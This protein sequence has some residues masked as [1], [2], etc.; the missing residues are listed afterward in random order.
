MDNEWFLFEKAIASYMKSLSKSAIVTHN[1]RDQ[2]EQTGASRQR[3]VI[4]VDTICQIIPVKVLISCKKY[5]RKLTEMDIDHFYG[6]LLNS[7]ANKGVLY[8]YAGFNTLAVSKA[9]KL[10]ISCFT[11]IDENRKNSPV[12]ID[13]DKFYVCY[14][15]FYIRLVEK[16]DIN[17]KYKQWRDIFYEKMENESNFTF[18]DSICK[19]I[20]KHQGEISR[21]LENKTFPKAWKESCE[22]YDDNDTETKL[23]IIF[24]EFWLVFHYVGEAKFLSGVFSFTENYLLGSFKLSAKNIHKINP[25]PDWEPIVEIPMNDK[26]NEVLTIF[27]PDIRSEIMKYIGDYPIE[28]NRGI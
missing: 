1:V 12:K 4:I 27:F 25:G 3:D 15:H 19:T 2:D 7:N 23:S 16:N 6:E 13:F 11:L 10:K 24:G 22:V 26:N 20:E 9:K 21:S 5:K 28:A 17:D 14:P 18:L 8:S